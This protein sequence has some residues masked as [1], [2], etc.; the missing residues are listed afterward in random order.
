MESLSLQVDR[1]EYNYD[2]LQAV[3][4]LSFPSGQD[5][6][7]SSVFPHFPL[8][9]LIF[10]QIFFIFFL[11]LVFHVD[12]SPTREGPGHV[13]VLLSWNILQCNMFNTWS[14]IMRCYVLK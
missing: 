7:I 10:P 2:R 12:G 8:G 1:K 6:N 9:F 5:K 13:T 3:A 11:I 4:S 14:S